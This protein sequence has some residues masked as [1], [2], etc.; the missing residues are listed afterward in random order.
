MTTVAKDVVFKVRFDFEN[1]KRQLEKEGQRT[2]NQGQP[3]DAR[4]GQGQGRRSAIADIATVAGI[5]AVGRFGRTWPRWEK[6]PPPG[7]I[8]KIPP[9]TDNID[10]RLSKIGRYTSEMYGERH[11]LLEEYKGTAFESF[12]RKQLEK[13]AKE[14]FGTGFLG[15]GSAGDAVG[16]SAARAT[17]K[18]TNAAAVG[19]AAKA[20][21]GVWNIPI[22]EAAG[23]LPGYMASALSV[24]RFIAPLAVAKTMYDHAPAWE[25]FAFRGGYGVAEGVKES[26]RLGLQGPMRIFN[27]MSSGLEYQSA[28]YK[29]GRGRTQNV[30]LLL[31]DPVEATAWNFS[32][33][34]KARDRA[35]TRRVA[36]AYGK[37]LEAEMTNKMDD[38]PIPRVINWVTKTWKQW[39]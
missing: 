34:E 1:A 3:K 7:R 6:I 8:R 10:E 5:N 16:G 18:I 23:R 39:F 2:S 9:S 4:T 26:I 12:R 29:M 36:I 15:G 14:K 21:K 13:F 11:R 17:S 24:G 30:G 31:N 32:E 22:S 27:S 35:F 37:R 38:T 25:A 33:L 20:A 19:M 28:V